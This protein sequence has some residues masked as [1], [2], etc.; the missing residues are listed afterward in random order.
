MFDLKI[1]FSCN[2]NC[3]HCVVAS[4]RPCGSLDI[5]H[6][7]AIIKNIPKGEGVV[8]TGGEP[9]IYSYLP[10]ILKLC[11]ERGLSTSIQ[12]NATGFANKNFA[13]KCIPYLDYAHVAIHSCYPD[14]HNRIVQDSKGVMWDRT[15]KGVR[16]LVELGLPLLSTQTVVTRYN[17]ETIYDTFSWIQEQWPG[18]CM[19]FTY[20]HM[21]GNAYENRKEVCFKYS[22]FKDEIHRVLERFHDHMFTESIPYCYLHPFVGK[23]HCLEDE[24]IKDFIPRGGIDFSLSK[25]DPINYSVE[26]LKG[27]AKIPTCRECIYDSFCPG[28]WKEYIYL[29]KESIDLF[30][31]KNESK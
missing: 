4:K 14:V 17:I 26:D 10:D 21:M 16:N 3:V 2:N 22:E 20:P 24:L 19:S 7:A 29:Y 11:K 1:G 9:S 15:V 13:K 12:T 23:V 25:N 5:P 6:I 30:S 8:I 27:R 31:I 28:V 18:I